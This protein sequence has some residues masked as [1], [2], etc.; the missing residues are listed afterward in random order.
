MPVKKSQLKSCNKCGAVWDPMF[1][2][3]CPNGHRGLPIDIDWDN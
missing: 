1:H 3:S 2:R